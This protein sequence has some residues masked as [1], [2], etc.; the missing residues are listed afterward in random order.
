[1]ADG[2]AIHYLTAVG[3]KGPH[4]IRDLATGAEREIYPEGLGWA[5]MTLSPD[6]TR[7]A[8]VDRRGDDRDEIILAT[9]DVRTGERRDLLTFA[10]PERAFPANAWSA[11]GKTILFWKRDKSSDK[12]RR[13]ELWAIGADGGEPRAMGLAIDDQRAPG[14]FSL[15]PDGRRLTYSAGNPQSEIWKLSNFLSRLEESD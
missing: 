9:L 8:V 15:H 13:R 12:P 14:D 7:F 5:W 4:R 11:D 6:G 2:R 1:M 10:G 3:D